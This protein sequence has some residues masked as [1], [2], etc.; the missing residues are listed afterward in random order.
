MSFN[1][2]EFYVR[3]LAH[4]PNPAHLIATTVF[5]LALIV[6]AALQVHQTKDALING[7]VDCT[8]PNAGNYLI[9]CVRKTSNSHVLTACASRTATSQA[10]Y[11]GES[12]PF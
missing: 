11:G 1:S 6:S 7:A 4:A 9:V 2:S 12:Y 8:N 3:R 5:H 10:H